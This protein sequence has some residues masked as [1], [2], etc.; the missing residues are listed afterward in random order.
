[1]PYNAKQQPGPGLRA[2]QGPAGRRPGGEKLGE[3]VGKDEAGG[4]SSRDWAQVGAA[5]RRA[6]V[7]DRVAAESHRF[8]LK[9]IC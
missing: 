3:G 2:H 7:S 8:C 1:M 4:W 6:K 9:E 5:A